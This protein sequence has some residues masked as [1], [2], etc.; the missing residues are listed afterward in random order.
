MAIKGTLPGIALMILAVAL[1]PLKDAFVRMTGGH[2]S[3][4]AI[5]WAQ[6]TFTGV[7]YL[8]VILA[9]Q[10]WSA[11]RPTRPAL[12]VLRAT[13]AVGGMGMFYWAISLI[14]LAEATAMQFIA[15]LV[16]TALSP[17]FLG[18]RF[19]IRRALSVAVGF[20]GVLVVLRPDFSSD[21]LGYIAGLGSG[22]FLGLFF[23]MNRKLAYDGTP[24][25]AV[26]Y[27]A[28]IGAIMLTPF[29]P[30]VWVVPRL[31]DAWLILGFAIVALLGQTCMFTAFRMG[32]ASLVAPFHFTQIVGATL[33]GYLFFREFPDGV[34]ILGIAII[35]L[36]GVYI[37]YRE[38]KKS[39]GP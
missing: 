30:A 28:A 13:F 27:S 2:Y 33:F 12:Q 10:G 17:L 9:R 20:A 34:A 3:A 24:I 4:I 19:G 1:F 5:T 32:E 23:I 22:F 7:I 29:V 37:G 8:A 14:P 6:F 21:Q 31:D 18:E 36:S 15:P 11:L 38:A 35:I 16:A 39:G 26:A 25:A